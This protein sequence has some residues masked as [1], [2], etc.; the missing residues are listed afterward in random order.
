MKK[1]VRRDFRCNGQL[2]SQSNAHRCV[3]VIVTEDVRMS[4]V[5]SR[6][7]AKQNSNKERLA[8][9]SNSFRRITF[10]HDA[11]VLRHC[12]KGLYFP[13][14]LNASTVRVEASRGYGKSICVVTFGT[15][16][17]NVSTSCGKVIR[18]KLFDKFAKSPLLL[19]C[20]AHPLSFEFVQTLF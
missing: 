15:M 9:L 20:L 4:R 8:D 3:V 11:N 16:T 7:W 10:T 14:P 6:G 2:Q 18:Q 5:N 1:C 17:Q 19:F 12:A 13:D